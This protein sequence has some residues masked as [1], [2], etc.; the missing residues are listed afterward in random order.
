MT[1]PPSSSPREPTGHRVGPKVLATR[2]RTYPD[3]KGALGWNIGGDGFR[4]VLSAE[5]STVVEK[6]LGDDVRKFL[7]DHGLTTDGRLDLVAACRAA[8]R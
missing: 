7:A 6:Y 5:I 4:I 2:S 1:A 8:R 3:T